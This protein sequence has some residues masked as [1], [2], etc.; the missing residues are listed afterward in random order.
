MYKVSGK[1]SEWLS[2]RLLNAE[3]ESECYCSGYTSSIYY[4]IDDTISP[5]SA[6]NPLVNCVPIWNSGIV[7]A[8]G[9][10]QAKIT[11]ASVLI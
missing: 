4:R 6:D 9:I 1:L 3:L 8:T 11:D 5:V 7:R 2:C 10:F